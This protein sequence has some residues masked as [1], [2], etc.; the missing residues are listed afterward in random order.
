[1]YS[2]KLLCSSINMV[3]QTHMEINQVFYCDNSELL[4][5][6]KFYMHINIC[7]IKTKLKMF[8]QLLLH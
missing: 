5:L 2:S 4:D 3:F 7:L 8:L 6:K 1:M